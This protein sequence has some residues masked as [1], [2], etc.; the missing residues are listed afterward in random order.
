MMFENNKLGKMVFEDDYFLVL[1]KEPGI[2]SVAISPLICH[3]LDKNT[4]GLLII[5]KNKSIKKKIQE[6]FKK[7]AVKKK[8]LVLVL[9]RL[10][11]KE[12]NEGF[13]FRNRKDKSKRKFISSFNI[14]NFKIS[15]KEHERYSK[16]KFQGKKI[17]F[18]E[19]FKK[20]SQKELNYFSLIEA[21]PKT[22]RTHQIRLHLQSLHHPILGDNLY[23]GKIKRRVWPE[24]D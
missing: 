8:Y 14:N 15:G 16:T 21:W 6:Q 24:N 18:F 4:S 20:E 13:I 1:D 5:A 11:G 12:M 19:I 10:E 2:N 22:G 23:G 9:G 3:R 7:R 17:Y